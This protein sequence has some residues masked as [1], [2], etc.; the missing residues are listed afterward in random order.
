MPDFVLGASL[1]PIECSKPLGWRCAFG[2]DHGVVEG[3]SAAIAP[4]TPGCAAPIPGPGGIAGRDHESGV[5][6]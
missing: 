4:A 1:G 3:N 5:S 6:C 2:Y